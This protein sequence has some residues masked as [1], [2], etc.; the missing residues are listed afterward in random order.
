MMEDEN[1]GNY[2]CDK[3]KQEPDKVEEEND[4]ANYGGGDDD[5]DDDDYDDKQEP[6]KLEENDDGDGVLELLEEF[7]WRMRRLPRADMVYPPIKTVAER[8]IPKK[9]EEVYVCLALLTANK[10]SLSALLQA[11][12][13]Q[14]VEII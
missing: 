6:N 7:E 12:T 4:N 3:D 11:E 9:S 10:R 13:E 2:D 1:D 14:V 5:D 8:E